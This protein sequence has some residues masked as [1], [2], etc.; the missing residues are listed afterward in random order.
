MHASLWS[1]GGSQSTLR[2]PT[3]VRGEHASNS[4]FIVNLQLFT[5]LCVRGV[6]HK[7]QNF[8]YLNVFS[9]ILHRPF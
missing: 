5:T 7:V 9:Y 3:K 6:Q 1:V 2:Q 8:G 4:L